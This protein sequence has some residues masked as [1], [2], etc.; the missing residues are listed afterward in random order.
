MWD[1]VDTASIVSI[2]RGEDYLAWLESLTLP[3][4]SHHEQLSQAAQQQEAKQH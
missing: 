3:N 2:V 1:A 4:S